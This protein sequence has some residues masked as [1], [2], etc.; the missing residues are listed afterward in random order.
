MQV[1]TLHSIAVMITL[2]RTIQHIE[3]FEKSYASWLLIVRFLI[4][5]IS[6]LFI[7]MCQFSLFFQL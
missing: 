5:R 1:M 2:D 6:I 4:K 3:L 7:D